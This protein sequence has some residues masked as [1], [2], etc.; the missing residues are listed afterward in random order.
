MTVGLLVLVCAATAAWAV[1][2][3]LGSQAVSHWLKAHQ[4]SDTLVGLVHAAYYLGVAV[5]SLAV[6][7]LT[8]RLGLGCSHVGMLVTAVSLAVFPAM[9]DA[10]GWL[11]IRL[12]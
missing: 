10:A 6:P 1:S 7:A 12:L 3:G 2:F 11:L 8:R 4:A 9:T 5:A